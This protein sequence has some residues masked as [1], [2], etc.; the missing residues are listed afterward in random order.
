MAKI[1][2]PGFKAAIGKVSASQKPGQTSENQTSHFCAC[3]FHTACKLAKTGKQLQLDKDRLI[4]WLLAGAAVP[5]IPGANTSHKALWAED[6]W[7]GH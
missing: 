6:K 5:K 3:K 4:G 2:F 1:W 7:A